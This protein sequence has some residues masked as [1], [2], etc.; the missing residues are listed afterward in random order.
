M[1]YHWM[2]LLWGLW[3]YAT[4]LHIKMDSKSTTDKTS[5][6]LQLHCFSKLA[7]Y[8]SLYVLLIQLKINLRECIFLPPLKM[9]DILLFYWPRA[10]AG[11]LFGLLARAWPPHDMN[12]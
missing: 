2:V 9:Y 3:A 5:H 10:H 12:L 11:H 1:I 7:S 4:G 8:F 6:I